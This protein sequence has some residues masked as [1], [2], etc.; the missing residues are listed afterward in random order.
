M[1]SKEAK[2]GL[3]EVQNLFT[4][5]WL[6][7][8]PRSRR[9]R[10]SK[11]EWVSLAGAGVGPATEPRSYRSQRSSWKDFI[12]FLLLP[13]RLQKQQTLRNNAHNVSNNKALPLQNLSSIICLGQ[14][15]RSSNCYQ[16]REDQGEH[17]GGAGTELEG[18]HAGRQRDAGRKLCSPAQSQSLS[19]Y[20]TVSATLWQTLPLAII[21]CHGA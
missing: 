19:K 2:R 15:A 16:K 5:G 13:S 14:L 17:M 3:Q 9:Q 10:K 21:T 4:S 1:H 11:T 7:C 18:L 12:A 8:I 20:T 6:Q